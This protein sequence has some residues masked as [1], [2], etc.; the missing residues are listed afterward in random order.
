MKST[1]VACSF[2]GLYWRLIPV[3]IHKLGVKGMMLIICYAIPAVRIYPKPKLISPAWS[4]QVLVD[5]FICQRKSIK[6]NNPSLI[7]SLNHFKKGEI[8]PATTLL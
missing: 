2:I 3:G 8:I 6:K 5:I 7:E 1:I 4:T